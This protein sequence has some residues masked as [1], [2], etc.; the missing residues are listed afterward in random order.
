M[1]PA[2]K[3]TVFGRRQIGIS[4]KIIDYNALRGQ[5]GA[6]DAGLP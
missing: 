3:F 1:K 6:F 5:P 2:A 4:R